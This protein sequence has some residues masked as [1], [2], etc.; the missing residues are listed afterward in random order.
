LGKR[1]WGQKVIARNQFRQRE[2]SF[3]SDGK[4]KVNFQVYYTEKKSIIA[5]TMDFPNNGLV[6]LQ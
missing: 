4:E 6:R 5:A 1:I 2:E 3:K